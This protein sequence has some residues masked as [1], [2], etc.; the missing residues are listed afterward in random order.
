MWT[1]TKALLGAGF[2]AAAVACA[3][4]SAA[5]QPAQPPAGGQLAA[6]PD[7]VLGD[8]R[9]PL[10]IIEYASLSCPHCADFHNVT[11]PRIKT[12]YIDTGK[13]KLI[14]REF[15]LNQ[16]AIYGAVLARC[17]GPQRF[18]P[19][20]E[21]MFKQQA[22]WVAATDVVARLTKIAQIGGMTAAEYQAYLND[23]TLTNQIVQTR[24]E[25]ENRFRV[26]STPT[27]IIGDQVVEGALPYEQFHQAIEDVMAGRPVRGA[28][29]AVSPAGGS[30]A[31]STSTYMMIGVVAL[32]IAAVG[33]FFMR[34][35]RAA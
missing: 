16:P 34:R 23:R 21:T 35:Q 30:A 17:S 9:A 22:A 1:Q 7:M 27:F 3:G 6:L 4:P 11:L 2:F 26:Q 18:F 29:G 19:F 33:F 25:G 10:T 20:V 13:A 5:Q 14:F 31:S 8:P 32:L 28:R 15:P 24:L 12:E